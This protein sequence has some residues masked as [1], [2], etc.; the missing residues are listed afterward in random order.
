[1]LQLRKA[2]AHFLP[3]L[4][5]KQCYISILVDALLFISKIFDKYLLCSA[6]NVHPLR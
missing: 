6:L 2:Y 1:M 3:L 5:R 4:G